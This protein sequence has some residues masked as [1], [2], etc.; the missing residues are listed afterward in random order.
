MALDPEKLQLEARLQALEY[1]LAEAFKLLYLATGVSHDAIS[2][3]HEELREAMRT[4][5]IPTSD[6]AAADLLAGEMQDATSRL[7]RMISSAVTQG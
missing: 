2:A 4:M 3:S 7:L 1:L 5:A 6:P